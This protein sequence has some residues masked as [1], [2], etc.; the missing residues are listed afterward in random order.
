MALGIITRFLLAFGWVEV[1][2]LTLELNV[3]DIGFFFLFG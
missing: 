2:I 1:N 3:N